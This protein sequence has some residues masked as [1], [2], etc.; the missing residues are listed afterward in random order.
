[1]LSEK[2]LDQV[3][4]ALIEAAFMNKPNRFVDGQFSIVIENRTD[5]NI[6]Q[7]VYQ[8]QTSHSRNLR[9]HSHFK[10]SNV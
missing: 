6:A 2:Y 3:P 7:G 9:L 8:P 5:V 10:R 1:M 4:K